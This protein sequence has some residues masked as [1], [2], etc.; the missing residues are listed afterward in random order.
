[1]PLAGAGAR[2]A[3]AQAIQKGRDLGLEAARKSGEYR[4]TQ[5][6]PAVAFVGVF[7]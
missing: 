2:F 7:G 3:I 6:D 1:M 5:F 4:L